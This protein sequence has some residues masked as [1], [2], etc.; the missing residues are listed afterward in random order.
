[1]MIHRAP[2]PEECFDL[3]DAITGRGYQS[4]PDVVWIEWGF[5]LRCQCC[6]GSGRHNWVP[7]SGNIQKTREYPCE[8]CAGRGE[9]KVVTP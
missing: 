3:E 8:S 2:E 1:M 5:A 7:P 9:F 4:Q 6:D